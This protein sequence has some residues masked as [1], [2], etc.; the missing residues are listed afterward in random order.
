[1]PPLTFGRFAAEWVIVAIY[2][3]TDQIK[4]AVEEA[5]SQSRPTLL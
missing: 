5:A 3:E 1:M 2:Y 4:K